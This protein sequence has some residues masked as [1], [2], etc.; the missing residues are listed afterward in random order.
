MAEGD[1]VSYKQV[2]L[3][4]YVSG[5]PE[6]SD[7]ELRSGKIRLNVAEGSKLVV[8]ENLYL[9]CDPYMRSRM[10][11]SIIRYVSSFSPGSVSSHLL[12]LHSKSLHY[13]D[14]VVSEPKP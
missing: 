7:F 12:L 4:D 3:R 6:E 13:S 11:N 14:Y 10:R 9:S 8:V 2:I 5:F 1:E